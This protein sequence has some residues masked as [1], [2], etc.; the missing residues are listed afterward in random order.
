MISRSELLKR[1]RFISGATTVLGLGALTLYPLLKAY[2]ETLD[3]LSVACAASLQP[4][5]E[6]SLRDAAASTLLLDLHLT[7]RNADLLPA[8]L[9]T[10]P[11]RFDVLVSQS[12]G[13]TR[14][15]LDE[16]R[17]TSAVP[18]AATEMVL[19]YSPRSAFA[20]DF[21]QSPRSTP[22]WYR[23]LQQ[24]GLRF[25]R[26]DPEKD[27]SGRA[28]ISSLLLAEKKYDQAGLARTVLGR[29]INPDQIASERMIATLLL[30]NAK[31][32][33]LCYKTSALGSQL[34]FVELASDINLGHSRGVDFTTTH[35][36]IGE[37]KYFPEPLIYYAATLSTARN[38]KEADAFVRWLQGPA[39]QRLLRISHY[40]S[41]LDEPTLT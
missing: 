21:A 19:A 34:P 28:V 35:F 26:P 18:F 11:S 8:F 22:A 4:V 23:T 25:V 13:Y 17:S 16:G 7:A 2:G 9:L 6:G 31:D 5:M 15:V 24:S 14:A 3:P 39:C 30:T 36:T 38:Q 40:N 20:S 27:P 32:A 41:A 10:D 12:P 33:A 37:T 29:I 1:R